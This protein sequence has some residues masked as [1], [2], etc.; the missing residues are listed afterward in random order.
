MKLVN[1][2]SKF[3]LML[4]II[5]ST[6]FAFYCLLSP[7]CFNQLHQIYAPIA[8]VFLFGLIFYLLILLRESEAK[9]KELGNENFRLSDDL[10]I[11]EDCFEKNEIKLDRIEKYAIR[12]ER[13]LN[14]DVRS[15]LNATSF[16]MEELVLKFSNQVIENSI[17]THELLSNVSMEIHLLKEN[18]GFFTIFHHLYFQVKPSASSAV[19]IKMLI[20]KILKERE[21]LLQ[22]RSISVDLNLIKL[23]LISLN[24]KNLESI[25]KILLD[26]F[27]FSIV[28]NTLYVFSQEDED[29]VVVFIGTMTQVEHINMPSLERR[30]INNHFI[31]LPKEGFVA[32]IDFAGYVAEMERCI[33][34]VQISNELNKSFEITIKKYS[35]INI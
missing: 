1:N 21:R 14:H 3:I 35:P 15:Q 27:I 24:H 5:F 12:L 30:L 13:V 16:L 25:F 2:T 20:E 9:R 19:N 18:V 8:F 28:Q 22:I 10:K 7:N 26:H 6:A 23:T 31:D 34:I 4:L 32:G 33:T 11:V 29:K 17:P